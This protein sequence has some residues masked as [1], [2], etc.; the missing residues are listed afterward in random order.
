[1]KR[2][3]QSADVNGD[4]VLHR[5]EFFQVVLFDDGLEAQLCAEIN[6]VFGYADYPGLW[7]RLSTRRHSRHGESVT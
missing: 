4:G 5:D 1:M 7:L 3:F 6:E 2:L